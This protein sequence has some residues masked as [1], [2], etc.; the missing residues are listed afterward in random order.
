M[1]R[2]DTSTAQVDKFG[3]GKNGFTGGNPQTGELPTALDQDYFDAIQEEICTVIE[4]SGQKLNKS[5][6]NQLLQAVRALSNG[7]IGTTRNARMSVTSA[8][9]SAVFTADEIITGTALGGIQ[10]RIGEFN[11]TINLGITGPGGMDNGTVPVSGFVA[12]YAIF[13]PSTGASALL[14]V[15]AT[16]TVAPE[17]YGG[18]NMPSG[19]S[20]SALVS[21]WRTS[22]SQFVP[23]FQQDR[24]ISIIRTN[25]LSTSTNTTSSTPLNLSALV[26]INAKNVDLILTS[27]QSSNGSGVGIIAQS[28]PSGISYIGNTAVA[29]SGTSASYVSGTL[30]LITAQT[31]YYYMVTTN[32]GSYVINL[33]KYSI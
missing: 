13:N 23:G 2:I 29:T 27:T 7:V 15:N 20:A 6:H 31:I 16:S 22:S 25:V 3:A 14:A 1:H 10:Y 11:K 24:S 4:S 33:G 12:I 9:A 8:S 21:V 28:S 26:P 30:P 19:Y 17:V 18:A 5:L 32:A